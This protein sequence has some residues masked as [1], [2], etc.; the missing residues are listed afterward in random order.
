MRWLKANGITAA[1]SE[2]PAD[3]LHANEIWIEYEIFK[4]GIRSGLRVVP[5]KV[6]MWELDNDKDE[7]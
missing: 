5:H 3:S 7:L 1:A 2:I 6:K 4:D